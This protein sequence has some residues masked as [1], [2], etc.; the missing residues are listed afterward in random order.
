M[1]EEKIRV[2]GS[3]Y[4]GIG[5]FEKFCSICGRKIYLFENY[6][7]KNVEFICDECFVK[8]Y[9][10]KKSEIVIEERTVKIFNK[11]Y[12]TKFTKKELEEWFKSQIKEEKFTIGG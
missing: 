5:R 12:K 1:K 3:L 10:E 7:N 8:I 11:I 2:V 4:P 9:D 6:S